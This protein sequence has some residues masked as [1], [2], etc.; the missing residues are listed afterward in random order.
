MSRLRQHPLHITKGRDA[1]KA[2]PT[3]P[4]EGPLQSL[5]LWQAAKPVPHIL[6]PGAWKIPGVAAPEKAETDAGLAPHSPLPI[7]GIGP[8]QAPLFCLAEVLVEP[9]RSTWLS[10]RH[11][12][13][14]LAI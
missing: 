13:G 2:D 11:L 1:E 6:L 7:L 4:P 5:Q 9:S 10:R 3:S 12:K 8:S 14:L